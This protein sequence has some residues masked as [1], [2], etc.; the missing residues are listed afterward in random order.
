MNELSRESLA[1]IRYLIQGE[2]YSNIY[3]RLKQWLPAECDL[4]TS[5]QIVGSTAV[6]YG[7]D[8]ITYKKYSEASTAEKEEIAIYLEQGKK[9][10]MDVVGNRMQFVGSLFIIP[11][12]DSIYWYRNEA[13]SVKVTLAH[14]GF[15]EKMKNQCIDVIEM[16]INRPRTLQPMNVTV[17][18]D[19]SDGSPAAGVKFRLMMFNNVTDCETNEQGNISLGNIMSGKTFAIE[20]STGKIHYDFVVTDGQAVYSFIIDYMVAYKIVVENRHGVRKAGYELS[21]NSKT[22]FTDENGQYIDKLLL[23][24]KEKT[25]TVSAKDIAVPKEFVVGRCAKENNFIVVIHEEEPP[26]PKPEKMISIR[27]LDYDSKP[28]PCLPF[29]VKTSTGEILEL[30]SDEHGVARVEAKNFTANKKN[31]VSFK[32]TKEYRESL[33]KKENHHGKK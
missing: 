12:E 30:V 4:F 21:V 3:Y 19:Y 10:V 16:L 25:V 24:T 22:V 27:L 1:K 29:V 15:T 31:T 18:V 7:D 33:N 2:D 32:I 20:D 6:W 26:T 5:I 14:W 23:D 28:L 11:N 8:N 9:L 13:G 17:H